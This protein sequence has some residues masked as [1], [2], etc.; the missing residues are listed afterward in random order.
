M[1]ES[2]ELQSPSQ[3]VDG[4]LDDRKPEAASAR[5]RSR[6]TVETLQHTLLLLHGDPRP[7]IDDKDFDLAADQFG[8]AFDCRA[9]RRVLH[10]ILHD[11]PDG[12]P[13]ERAVRLDEDR[14]R[15]FRELAGNIHLPQSSQRLK[16]LND[17]QNEPGNIHPGFRRPRFGGIDGGQIDKLLRHPACPVDALLDTPERLL[18]NLGIGRA[19]SHL[20]LRLQAGKGCLQ[21]MGR[22]GREFTLPFPGRLNARKKAVQGVDHRPKLRWR[23][24]VSEGMKLGCIA[25]FQTVRELL[26]GSKPPRDTEPDEAGHQRHDEKRRIE[27]S[28]DHIID[29]TVADLNAVSHQNPDAEIGLDHGIN[30][31]FDTIDDRVL[32]TRDMFRQ[33]SGG[34]TVRFAQETTVDRPDLAGKLAFIRRYRRDR[35]VIRMTIR[36]GHVADNANID[37]TVADERSD[38]ACRYHQTR[39]Q[40]MLQP[41]LRAGINPHAAGQPD[42]ARHQ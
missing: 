12:K 23:S 35:I 17:I 30:A 41:R 15:L 1:I 26:Q 13:K 9:L 7:F 18:L 37:R 42:D 38:H 16:F 34:R 31:P 3:T 5:F 8:A 36:G 11:I 21:L 4:H 32:K 20:R 10:G 19:H 40:N 29:K 14:I 2:Q 24:P 25:C 27:K 6:R 39:I 22:I 33:G 28:L